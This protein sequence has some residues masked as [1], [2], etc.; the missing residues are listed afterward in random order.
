MACSDLKFESKIIQEAP[1]VENHEHH[2]VTSENASLNL[3]LAISASELEPVVASESENHTMGRCINKKLAGYLC[4]DEIL[5]SEAL[6]PLPIDPIF[7]RYQAHNFRSTYEKK[8]PR[9]SV[10]ADLTRFGAYTFERLNAT[11]TGL[12]KPNLLNS[13]KYFKACLIGWSHSRYMYENITHGG[14]EKDNNNFCRHCSKAHYPWDISGYYYRANLVNNNCTQIILGLGKRPGRK[15]TG[16][17]VFNHTM[18]LAIDNIS[19]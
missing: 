7:T 10:T 3:K 1:C 16:F 15:V 13:A 19:K 4:G 14:Y 12:D 6:Y 18:K 11:Y 5:E 8:T 2:R 17:T 9:C